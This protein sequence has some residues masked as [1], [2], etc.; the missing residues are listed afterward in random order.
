MQRPVLIGQFLNAIVAPLHVGR[1]VSPAGVGGVGEW[2]ATLA[3]VLAVLAVAGLAARVAGRL[4]NRSV[5]ELIVLLDESAKFY[6]RW[7]EHRLVG[8]PPV[9]VMVEAARCQRIIELLESHGGDAG[10][11]GRAARGPIDGLRAWVQVLHRRIAAQAGVPSGPAY[12]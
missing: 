12:A 2:F 3:S 4:T 6:G 8:A 9:E 7:P 11:G 1:G 10:V 5:P